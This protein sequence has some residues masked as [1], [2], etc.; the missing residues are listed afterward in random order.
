VGHISPHPTT[1]WTEQANIRGKYTIRWCYS[2]KK[3]LHGTKGKK[4]GELKQG[5]AMFMKA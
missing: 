3:N 2:E 4:R 1:N 5:G